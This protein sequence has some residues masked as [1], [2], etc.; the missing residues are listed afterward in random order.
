MLLF[1][2]FIVL[3][4]RNSRLKFWGGVFGFGWLLGLESAA[5]PDSVKAVIR[6]ERTF[7]PVDA[8]ILVEMPPKTLLVDEVVNAVQ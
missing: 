6:G 8:E 5:V 4:L 1:L 7:Y 3:A 2:V